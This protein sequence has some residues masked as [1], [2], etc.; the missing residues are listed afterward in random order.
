MHVDYRLLLGYMTPHNHVACSNMWDDRWQPRWITSHIHLIAVHLAPLPSRQATAALSVSYSS[1]SSSVAEPS[2]FRARQPSSNKCSASD[3]PDEREGSPTKRHKFRTDSEGV[4][5][6][7]AVCLSRRQHPTVTCDA[8]VTWDG[9]FKTF[10]K[11]VNKL[12]YVKESNAKICARWQ[13]DDCTLK[14]PS[15]HIC[16]GCGANSHGVQRCPRAQK[17]P[18]ADAL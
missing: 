16:S 3:Y 11:R 5:P 14:H 10:A 18:T 12:I 7:C 17:A 13:R 8:D 6:I 2:P 9:K 4:L 1:G 15:Q